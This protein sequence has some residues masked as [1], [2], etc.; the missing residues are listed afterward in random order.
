M[1]VLLTGDLPWILFCFFVFVFVVCFFVL[2]FFVF[3]F[4]TV[5]FI[6]SIL[7]LC[8]YGFLFIIIIIIIIIMFY[9]SFLI[10][11]HYLLR[12]YIFIF[13]N[14][15]TFMSSKQEVEGSIPSGDFFFLP[16][17]FFFF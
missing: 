2:F 9:V 10:P 14:L 6:I 11:D 8:S 3:F 5:L 4:V 17:I 7:T 12:F 16:S 15:L 1:P 13:A